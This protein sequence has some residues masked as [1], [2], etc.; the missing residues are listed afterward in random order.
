[1]VVML[2]AA[3]VEVLDE[4][5]APDR[6]KLLVEAA[7]AYRARGSALRAAGRKEAAEADVKRADAL[8]A[9]ARK[10][11]AKPS[12]KKERPSAKKKA[13]PAQAAGRIRLVNTWT[14]PVTVVIGGV[15]HLLRAGEEKTVRRPLGPFTYEVQ[16]L[17][18][19]G[20]GQLLK[21]ETYTLRI[22]P[23]RK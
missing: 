2:Y 3:E 23:R 9:R 17:H 11:A 6:D 13:V 16:V 21:D 7:Q 8:E 19:W 15:A 4:V 1:M 12:R 20:K 18:R 5:E 22:H 10:L 14:Q